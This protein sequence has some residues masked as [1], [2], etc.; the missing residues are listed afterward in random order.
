MKPTIF[1]LLAAILALAS[2]QTSDNDSAIGNILK[3]IKTSSLTFFEHVFL[4]MIPGIVKIDGNNS[5]FIQKLDE[6]LNNLVTNFA[7]N[8]SFSL[9]IEKQR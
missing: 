7:C 4:G 9:L 2:A 1:V 3:C 5:E 8:D 6:N